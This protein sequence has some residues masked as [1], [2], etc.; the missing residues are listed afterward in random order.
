MH[1][2]SEKW[3]FLIHDDQLGRFSQKS[4]V[5]HSGTWRKILSMF[6]FIFYCLN[7]ESSYDYGKCII[8]IGG[9]WCGLV[10]NRVFATSTVYGYLWRIFVVN[11]HSPTALLCDI[12]THTV[13]SITS[14]S[15]QSFKSTGQCIFTILRK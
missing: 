5:E 12:P 4:L 1:L 15:T 3:I 14:L 10:P 2:Y 8:K 13:S 7:R 11:T 9:E 6:S